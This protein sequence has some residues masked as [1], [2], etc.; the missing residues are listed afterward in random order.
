MTMMANREN[1]RLQLAWLGAAAMA[2]ACLGQSGCISHAANAVPAYRLNE[3]AHLGSVSAKVPID[4]AMLGQDAPAEHLIGPGDVL[5][6]YVYGILPPGTEEAPVVQ[7]ATTLSQRYYPPGGELQLPTLG[8]PVEVDSEGLLTLPVVGGLNVNGLTLSTARRAVVEAYEAQDE[9]KE[10]RERISVTLIKRRVH[11]IV[12]IREDSDTNVPQTLVKT[13]IP[14]AKHGHAEVIDLPTF[15]NDV[16]HAL[17]ET[18]GLPGID[19][20]NEVW[21]FRNKKAAMGLIDTESLVIGADGNLDATLERLKL[22]RS[23][24]RIPLGTFPGEPFSASPEDVVLHD[25]DVVF[26]PPRNKVFYTGGLLAAGQIPLPRDRDLDVVEAISLA[27]GSVGGP[28]G[29]SA[30]VFRAGAGPGNIIPPTRVLVLRKTAPGRQL[31]IRVDLAR[32]LKDPKERILIQSDD[33]VMLYYKPQETAGN[34]ALNFFNFNW[35]FSPP[36]GD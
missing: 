10:G 11:R 17:A 12:V 20:E 6:V 21:V 7:T 18:G 3:L 36:I 33:V 23:M 13:A 25:G 31:L 15:E 30:A 22:E 1:A 34:V 9:I 8:I 28:G 5:G 2:F 27:G 4:L 24:I 29:A 16:L 26:V 19:A 14:Y 35:V 32:A